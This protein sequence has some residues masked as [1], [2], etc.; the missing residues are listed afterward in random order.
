MSANIG[1]LDHYNLSTR[2][3]SETVRFYS[4]VLGLEHGWRPPL[5]MPGAWLYSEGHPIVHINDISGTDRPQEYQTG[6][7]DHVAFS[8]RGFAGMKAHLTGKGIEFRFNELAGGS[9]W[10]IFLRD[11]NGVMLE[12]NFD[13]AKE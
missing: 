10:Q 11:P 5:E 9:R 12:L 13:V 8:S 7:I 6:P 3:L 4:E 2:N 1:L